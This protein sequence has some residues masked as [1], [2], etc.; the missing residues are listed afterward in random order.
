MNSIDSRMHDEDE[1]LRLQTEAMLQAVL[2]ALEAFV[3]A[4]SWAEARCVLETHSRELLTDVA[5]DVL[6][7]MMARNKNAEVVRMLAQHRHVLMRCRVV[8]IDVAFAELSS[9]DIPCPEGVDLTLWQRALQIDNSTAMM[10]FLAEYPDLITPIYRR[11]SYVLGEAHVSLLDG[12]L[13]LLEADTWTAARDIVEAL[14]ALLGLEADL[15]L[16]QYSASLARVGNYRA[17]TVVEM[18]RW[19][20]ARCRMIGV[21]EAF[22]ERLALWD[23]IQVGAPAIPAP[24]WMIQ[25]IVQTL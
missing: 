3:A 12:M 7:T 22:G 25:D 8:G 18:R 10:D 4:D 20:L 1:S 23:G 13:N 17:V 6:V 5:D 2:D 9:V 15:W 11:M 21:A 24:H 14:P 19:L 16:M